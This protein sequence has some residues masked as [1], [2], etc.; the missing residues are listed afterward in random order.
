MPL[1]LSYWQG[2]RGRTDGIKLLLDHAE[3]EFTEAN[4][5]GFRD[6]H[7]VDKAPKSKNNPLTNLPHITFEEDGEKIEIAHTSAIMQ[8]L[9]EKYGY[10]G[11]TTIEKYRVYGGWMLVN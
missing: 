5:D 1:Q 7:F 11:E 4:Y 2:I 10:T 9:A 8:I 6:W 3:V